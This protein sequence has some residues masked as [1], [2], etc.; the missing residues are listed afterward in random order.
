[1][2]VSGVQTLSDAELEGLGITQI[3]I[4]N[5]IE[6]AVRDAAAGRIWTTPK[7][8]LLPGD[9]RYMMTTL[10]ASDQP[11]L[12]VVKFVMVSPDNHTKGLPAINGSILIHDSATGEL[13]A[14]LDAQEGSIA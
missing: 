9:G 8:A 1:M 7:A 14:V 13:K 12:S 5:T 3:E 11:G 10:S 4:V 2:S 6:E